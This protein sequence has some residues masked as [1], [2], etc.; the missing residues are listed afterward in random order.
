MIPRAIVIHI[1]ETHYYGGVS[2]PLRVTSQGISR[3]DSL[4]RM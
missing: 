4:V 1:P 2:Q 3:P